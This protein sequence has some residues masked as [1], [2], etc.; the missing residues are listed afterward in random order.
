MA[1]KYQEVADSAF[2]FREFFRVWTGETEKDGKELLDQSL[3]GK[4]IHENDV[5]NVGGKYAIVKKYTRPG[6]NGD[7]YVETYDYFVGTAHIQVT[8][9]YRTS[10]SSYWKADFDRVINSIEWYI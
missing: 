9:S 5:K 8:M 6:L 2:N 4:F 1:T 3:I 7:V 10:E